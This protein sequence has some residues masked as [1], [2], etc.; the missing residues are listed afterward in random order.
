MKIYN[1]RLLKNLNSASDL[2]ATLSHVVAALRW[3]EISLC[4]KADFGI[5]PNESNSYVSCLSFEQLS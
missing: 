5:M 2:I 1:W 3:F 4:S